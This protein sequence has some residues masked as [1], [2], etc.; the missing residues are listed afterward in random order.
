MSGEATERCRRLHRGAPPGAAGASR[1]RT[2]ERAG[3]DA[4]GG[5]GL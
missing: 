4:S 1:P 5:P 2:R 3:A